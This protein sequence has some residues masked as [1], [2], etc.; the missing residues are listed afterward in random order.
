MQKGLSE[1]AD[2]AS[3]DS[4]PE[5][6]KPPL[7]KIDQY[8]PPLLHLNKFLTKTNFRYIDAKIPHLT[9]RATVSVLCCIG[10]I[11]MFGMRETMGM[12]NA[13]KE[14]SSSNPNN[15]QLHKTIF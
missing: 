10:F 2:D 11:I 3:I 14:V 9:R 7:R 5:Y 6:Q 1:Q 4:L 12:V 8:N 13:E 15:V